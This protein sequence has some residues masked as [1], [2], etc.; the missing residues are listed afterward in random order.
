[1][2][3]ELIHEDGKASVF[4][5]L[6]Q[7]LQVLDE[8]CGSNRL[9]VYVVPFDTTVS[10]H[11]N[12]DTLVPS[13]YLTLIYR[14]VTSFYR[15]VN[16]LK[17]EL[18]KVQLI[19]EKKLSALCIDLIKLTEDVLASVTEL[20]Q[21]MLRLQLLLPDCFPFDAVLKIEPA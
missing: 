5:Y 3:T 10:G 15:P 16:R 17:T 7:L 1:V 18:G 19:K 11:S 9:V 8:L 20:I 6:P 13:V 4:V 21:D 12:Y 14:L 2:D